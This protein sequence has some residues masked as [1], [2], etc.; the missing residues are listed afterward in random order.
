MAQ[1]KGCSILTYSGLE[2]SNSGVQA[3]RALWILQ[4]LAGHLDVPGGKLFKM[5]QRL[6]LNR[7]LTDPPEGASTPKP[8]G[9]DVYPLYYETR[10]EAH[11]ALLPRA[12]LENEPYPIRA[13][14]ISGASLITSWPNPDLWR[15]ALADLDFLVVVDRFP[16]ADGLYADLLLPA[17]TLFEI[18]SYMV[19]DDTYVQ[20]RRRIIEPLMPHT[21]VLALNE[22]IRGVDVQAHGVVSIE[23]QGADIPS[24]VPA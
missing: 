3:I 24:L 22:I 16:T 14:I 8:I 18:E 10:R 19:Y 4:A 11:A 9:A 20:L 23:K 1:A 13:L 15:R 12:I 17:T 7:L 6:Q 2:Y 5:P 21:P